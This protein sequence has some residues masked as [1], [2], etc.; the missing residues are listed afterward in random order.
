MAA[1]HCHHVLFYFLQCWFSHSRLVCESLSSSMKA[2][3]TQC[4][5]A[6]YLQELSNVKTEGTQMVIRNS[7]SQD[8]LSGKPEDYP[9]QRTE[10]LGKKR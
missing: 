8:E 1:N 7:I 10:M 3:R 9:H 5:A 6:W 2:I 4:S